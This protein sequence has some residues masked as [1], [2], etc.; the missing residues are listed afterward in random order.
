MPTDDPELGLREILTDA[1][2]DDHTDH[3]TLDAFLEASGCFDDPAD[4][5][6]DHEVLESGDWDAWVRSATPFEGWNAMLARALR[7]RLGDAF[8]TTYRS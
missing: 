5:A 1:W 8:V 6:L 2:L 7:D 3:A 4:A